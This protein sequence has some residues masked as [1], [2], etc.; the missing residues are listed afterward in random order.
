MVLSKMNNHEHR[1]KQ[2]SESY[3]F[4]VSTLTAPTHSKQVPWTLKTSVE[5]KNVIVSHKVHIETELIYLFPEKNEKNLKNGLNT[6][7]HAQITTFMSVPYYSLA[8]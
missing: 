3:K 2:T 6:T 4:Q 5:P 8:H 1:T 7:R